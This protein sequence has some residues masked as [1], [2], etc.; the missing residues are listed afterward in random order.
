MTPSIY[1]LTA[2]QT[3]YNGFQTANRTRQ[4]ESQVQAARE[5][6][7]VTEQTV[8]LNAVTAYMNLLRDAAILDLQRRNVEVLAGAIAADARP[9]Q[10]RR[11]DAHRRCAI[12]I[13]ACRRPLAGV[14]RGGDLQGLGC[15]LSAGDRGRARQACAGYSGRPLFAAHSA[16]LG[17]GR[18]ARRIRR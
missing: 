12:G 9:L 16:G 14:E 17:R 6:L 10:C 1:G 18:H 11:G 15:D 4:A 3:L 13:A 7:R 5:Q 2:T 8:L